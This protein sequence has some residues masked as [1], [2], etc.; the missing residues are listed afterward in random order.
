MAALGTQVDAGALGED[1][2]GIGPPGAVT[3]LAADTPRG[4]SRARIKATPLCLLTSRAAIQVDQGDASE[5][6]GRSWEASRRPL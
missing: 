3:V 6:A 4:D 5:R 2:R 1:G